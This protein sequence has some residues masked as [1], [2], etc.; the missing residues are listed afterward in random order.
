MDAATYRF[1]STAE[2]QL[3]KLFGLPRLKTPK[4]K[5]EGPT[6]VNRADSTSPA[7][8]RFRAT[9]TMT[10]LN[11]SG[12]MLGAKVSV[13]LNDKYKTSEGAIE[14]RADPKSSDPNK[15]D[16]IGPLK[17]YFHVF[18]SV[19]TPFFTISNKEPIDMKATIAS[20]PPDRGKY[21]QYSP[22]RDLYDAIFRTIFAQMQC[23]V[24][25]VIY[26]DGAP[27]RPRPQG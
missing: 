12:K 2:V 20:I 23:A 26:V 16:P 5:L 15:P 3:T 8:G 7:P 6:R 10:E 22:P 18:V 4:I 19:K 14:G 11:L 21:K 24:H 13:T 1:N 17:S 27:D 9:T 25:N